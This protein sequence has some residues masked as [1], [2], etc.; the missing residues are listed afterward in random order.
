LYFKNIDAIEKIIHEK[1][2]ANLGYLEK[3]QPWYIPLITD[4]RCENDC[5]NYL[6]KSEQHKSRTASLRFLY[7]HSYGELVSEFHSEL[8]ASKEELELYLQMEEDAT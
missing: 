4:L 3:T 1:F 8:V 2:T 5:I 6:L 7:I